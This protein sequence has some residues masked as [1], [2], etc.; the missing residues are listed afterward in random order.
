MARKLGCCTWIFGDQ[1]LAKTAHL[2]KEAGLDGVELFG[3]W[4]SIDAKE[5][6]KVL[7]GNGLEVFSITPADADISHPD[8]A[9]RLAALDYY[10]GLADFTAALIAPMFCMHGQVG[11]IR[12]VSSQKEE[13]ALLVEATAQI[14][15]LATANGLNVAFEILNRYESHQIRTVAEGLNLLKE[16]GA[17]KLSLLADAYHMNIEEADP[18]AALR[19][20]GSLIGLYHAADSNRCAI[21][22]G[23]TEFASQIS[24]LD[25]I[26]YNGPIIIET[27]VPGADPFNTDKGAGFRDILF[28]QL[29]TSKKELRALST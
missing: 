18:A 5:A 9:Q 24:A 23:H 7:D 10:K 26:H 27:A 12:P 15:A 8:K 2:I 20:G 29:V 3:D 17:N 16:V 25:E 28:Q 6:K 11:R 19:T 21:G 13:D 4:K 14:C 22:E 1:T